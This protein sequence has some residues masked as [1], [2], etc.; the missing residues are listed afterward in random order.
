MQPRPHRRRA[1]R[2][3]DRW[4]SAIHQAAERWRDR[5]RVRRRRSI[6]RC[7]PRPPQCQWVPRSPRPTC[8]FSHASRSRRWCVRQSQAAVEA[9][10]MQQPTVGAASVGRAP[11]C[12]ERAAPRPPHPSMLCAGVSVDLL[13]RVARAPS[14]LLCAL[15]R[16][17]R[18]A[19]SHQCH[20]VLRCRPSVSP[21]PARGPTRCARA[22][23]TTTRATLCCV[24]VRGCVA[25]RALLSAD[26]CAVLRWPRYALMSAPP[27]AQAPIV[28]AAA[29]RI[30]MAQPRP[31]VADSRERLRD[32]V[33]NHTVRLLGGEAS[34]AAHAACAQV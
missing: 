15:R 7:A 27:C 19:R 18:A 12:G 14:P 28:G 5:R 23:A 1:H 30:S 25:S 31:G 34:A 21:P 4:R 2:R 9:P 11:E 17:R 29:A 24:P 8:A 3:T 10:P 22:A 26:L 32:H 13:R 6:C 33:C 16:A 20:P